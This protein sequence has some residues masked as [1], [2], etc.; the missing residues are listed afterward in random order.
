MFSWPVKLRSSTPNTSARFSHDYNSMASSS[1][2]RSANSASFHWSSSGI[3]SPLTEY[4]PFPKKFE[5]HLFAAFL[6][7]LGTERI[8]T[9]AY[10]PACNGLVER[11]HR[12]LKQAIMA[13]GRRASWLDHL[14]FILLG[15]R[16]AVKVDPG[17]SSAQLVYGTPLRLPSDVF[18]PSSVPYTDQPAY[19]ARL[20]HAFA[21]LQFTPTRAVASSP[22]FVPSE[23]DTTSQLSP[24]TNVPQRPPRLLSS[25][26]TA[27]LN[28]SPST[29]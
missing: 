16:A 12:H 27:S 24:K 3:R 21:T 8:R 28:P 26:S 6:R 15:I 9:S 10:H 13:H 14:P 23:L 22:P 5:S 11:F 25:M 20:R 18:V 29:G 2:P 1:T 7:L 4:Y 17:C 19:L